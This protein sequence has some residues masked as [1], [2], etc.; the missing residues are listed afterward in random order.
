MVPGPKD[1]KDAYSRAQQ[2]MDHS[3]RARIGPAESF[4]LLSQSQIETVPR[5]KSQHVDSS[6]RS[7]NQG[8]I[9]RPAYAYANVS[10]H[11]SG[12]VP[13]TSDDASSVESVEQLLH[14]L[15]S[16]TGIDHPL[17]FNC[18]NLLQRI[19]QNK[20][21]DVQRERDAYISFERDWQASKKANPPPQE[22]TFAVL[23]DEK[24]ELERQQ[25]ILR[26]TLREEEEEA[27]ALEAEL[28]QVQLEED[29]LDKRE[30]K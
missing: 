21:E 28:R 22:S 25:I 19:L 6:A 11:I 1:S 26:E 29:E 2:A 17:C 30:T 4:I 24:E 8:V 14:A 10:F 12:V 3:A 15:S 9:D 13:S 20:L 27:K 18:A 23:E 16:T 5:P 7:L